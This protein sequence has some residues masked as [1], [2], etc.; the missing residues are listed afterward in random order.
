MKTLEKF[1]SL[2]R[3]A[4]AVLALNA[5]IACGD[6]DN[7]TTRVLMREFSSR[8]TA[9]N[10]GDCQASDP[11]EDGGNKS[12]ITCDGRV[13]RATFAL[14][15]NEKGGTNYD[16]SFGVVPEANSTPQ[17]VHVVTDSS[18]DCN[19]FAV[20]NIRTHRAPDTRSTLS[21][22]TINPDDAE[23]MCATLL[24]LV[25][26]MQRAVDKNLASAQ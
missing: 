22:T 16:Y 21:T 10:K 3:P 23:A 18:G 25:E 11:Q 26:G 14:T 9:L 2:A 4:L 12:T 7:R 15:P 8:I 6:S 17:S 19:S 1:G 24:V 13:A 5:A 20:Q